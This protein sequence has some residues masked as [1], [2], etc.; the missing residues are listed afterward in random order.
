[1]RLSSLDFLELD[2]P[3]PQTT[4]SERRFIPVIKPN[5]DELQ[6]QKSLPVFTRPS[7]DAGASVGVHRLKPVRLAP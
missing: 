5:H 3:L 1:M 4:E 2:P 6:A 7:S